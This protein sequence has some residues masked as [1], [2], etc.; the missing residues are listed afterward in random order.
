MTMSRKSKKF[1]ELKQ[2][3]RHA[4]ELLNFVKTLDDEEII[5]ST[6]ESVIELLEEEINK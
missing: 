6:I 4:V 1:D 3:L 2:K 5:R